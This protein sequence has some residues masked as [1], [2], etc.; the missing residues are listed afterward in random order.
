MPAMTIRNLPV[1]IH[2]ALKARAAKAGRSTE[3]E[4]RSILEHAVRPVERIKV[5][6][7]IR[8]LVNKYGGADFEIERDKTPAHFIDFIGPEFD[9]PESV[10]PDHSQPKSK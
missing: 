5:G 10:D 7:E 2:L 4:V 8:K 1:E 6:T 9:F 3:A